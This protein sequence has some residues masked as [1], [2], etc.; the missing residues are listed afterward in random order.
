MQFLPQ[1][2]AG[3]PHSGDLVLSEN[4]K[5]IERMPGLIAEDSRSRAKCN[6]VSP[7][8]WETLVFNS[9]WMI[10]LPLQGCPLPSCGFSLILPFTITS[11]Y[12]K[13]TSALVEWDPSSWAWNGR[14]FLILSYPTHFF[15]LQ[16]IFPL[17]YKTYLFSSFFVLFFGIFSYTFVNIC[18]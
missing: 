5:K 1:C 13:P 10:I 16:Y 4:R 3:S 14:F 11:L 9:N 18:I 17:F 6:Y 2:R 7:I 8:S 15:L 12:L